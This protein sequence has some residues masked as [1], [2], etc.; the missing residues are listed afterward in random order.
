MTDKAKER[1]K[2]NAFP[3]VIDNG[4]TQMIHYGMNLREYYAGLAMQA[5]IANP[6]RYKYIAEKVNEGMT[7]NAA[8]AKN[9]HKA[10]LLADA[11]LE[12][13]SKNE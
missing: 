4:D 5:L 2:Q 10:V 3:M 6:E 11:L 12:E 13:L 8:S 1:G 9:A 7:N